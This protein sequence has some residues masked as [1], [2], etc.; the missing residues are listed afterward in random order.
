MEDERVIGG[1]VEGRRC[2]GVKRWRDGAGW[3]EMSRV[4]THCLAS[5]RAWS[6]DSRSRSLAI[7]TCCVA[8]IRAVSASS[9]SSRERPSA[10]CSLILRA[11]LRSTYRAGG[12]R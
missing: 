11:S 4:V 7:A 2:G 6:A 8:V 1:G 9:A 10:R 12:K 3:D 5:S